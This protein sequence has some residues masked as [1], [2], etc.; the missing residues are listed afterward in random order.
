MICWPPRDIPFIGPK[1]PYDQA[2][3][4]LDFANVLSAGDTIASIGTVVSSPADLQII[5]SGIQPG[6]LGTPTAVSIGL[7]AG[8]I[9]QNYTVSAEITTSTGEE[10]SRSIIISVQKL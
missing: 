3:Y 2:D 10:F 7:A 6:L 4:L 8:T 5:A 1:D 9:G